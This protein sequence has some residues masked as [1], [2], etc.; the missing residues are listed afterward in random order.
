MG[1]GPGVCSWIAGRGAWA[2]WRAC[3]RGMSSAKVKR[4]NENEVVVLGLS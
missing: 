4:M 2:S 3:T 1:V